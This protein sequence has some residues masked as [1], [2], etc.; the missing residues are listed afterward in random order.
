MELMKMGIKPPP[1]NYTREDMKDWTRE[2]KS[3]FKSQVRVNHATQPD[4]AADYR[5]ASQ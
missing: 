3:M 1:R 5:R 4:R 2:E